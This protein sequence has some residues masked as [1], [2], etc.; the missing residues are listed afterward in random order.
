[1]KFNK[2]IFAFLVLT[3]LVDNLFVN[4]TVF[5]EEAISKADPKLD[6]KSD[7]KKTDIITVEAQFENYSNKNSSLIKPLIKD[8][9]FFSSSNDSHVHM[10]WSRILSYLLA[11]PLKILS[12]ITSLFYNNK[13][14]YNGNPI[15]LLNP[16]ETIPEKESIEAKIT[17]LGHSTFLIQM[18]GLNI[19][20]DPIFGDVKA[21]PYPI[22]GE[23]TITKR[24]LPVCIKLENMPHIDA[25]VISHNHHDHMDRD[26]LM[27][28]SK[29]Y[30]P[31]I[32][33][34][35]GNKE[36]VKNMGFSKI[37]ENTWWDLN[38]ITKN[39]YSLKITCLPAYHWSIRSGLDY[40]KSLWSGWMINSNDTSIYFAGDTTYDQNLF[41][42]IAQTFPNIDMALMPIG[43]TSKEEEDTDHKKHEHVDA[44]QAVDAFIDLDAKCFVPMHFATF[45]LSKK[46]LEYPIDRLYAYWKLKQEA[47]ELENKKLLFARC[48]QEYKVKD[49]I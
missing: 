26:S 35:E 23:I 14:V 18:D 9:N 1:M 21:G 20:T 8:N 11:S 5:A 31:I 17:W 38:K 10:P 15:T 24:A 40:R 46:T 22:I 12:K 48:G 29:K 32:F 2:I 4:T 41:K 16:K 47:K 44:V 45:F 49:E 39:N 34:P 37:I 25:I 36:T 30:D 43:P 7:I 42:Q 27:A 6:P 3:L 13:E 33:V 28:L 19:L